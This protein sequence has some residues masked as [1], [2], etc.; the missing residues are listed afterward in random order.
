[1]GMLSLARSHGALTAAELD[2]QEHKMRW[3]AQLAHFNML[4]IFTARLVDPPFP[5]KLTA[6][7]VEV[8][9]WTADGKTSADIAD[10]L[11]LSRDTVNFHI[12]NA[13]TK[14]QTSNKTAATVRAAMLGLLHP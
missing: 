7:E 4:R 1:M 5:P 12:K 2:C 8:L 13:I 11:E 10:L 14:L 3:L 9:Q 6:R